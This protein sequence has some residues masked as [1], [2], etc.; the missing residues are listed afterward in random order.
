MRSV[1]GTLGMSVGCQTLRCIRVLSVSKGLGV[2]LVSEGPL[3]NSSERP[4]ILIFGF[5]GPWRKMIAKTHQTPLKNGKL[6]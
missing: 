2:S 6:L 5:F 1:N 3:G 4:S